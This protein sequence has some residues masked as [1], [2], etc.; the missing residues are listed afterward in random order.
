MLQ[1]F[2]FLVLQS[3]NYYYSDGLCI[4]GLLQ[5]NIH[6]YRALQVYPADGLFI[7]GLLQSNIHTYRKLQAEQSW[8][9]IEWK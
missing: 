8:P 2:C 6:T 7:K 3:V 1:K 9:Y 4:K 5:S